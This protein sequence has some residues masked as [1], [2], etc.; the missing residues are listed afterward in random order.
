MYLFRL[1]KREELEEVENSGIDV[2][3]ERALAK[4]ATIAHVIVLIGILIG[5]AALFKPTDG[6]SIILMP[7]A[8]IFEFSTYYLV[9]TLIEISLNIKMKNKVK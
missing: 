7:I 2:S 6:G 5:I 1:G 8:A 4:W 9:M 3:S